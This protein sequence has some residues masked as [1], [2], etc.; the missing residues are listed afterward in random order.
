[1]DSKCSFLNITQMLEHNVGSS[2]RKSGFLK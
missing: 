2:L 1:M